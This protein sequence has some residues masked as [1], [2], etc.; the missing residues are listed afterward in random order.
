MYKNMKA[1]FRTFL[2]F[3]A[4]CAFLTGCSGVQSQS[5]E[6]NFEA[7]DKTDVIDHTK[8]DSGEPLTTLTITNDFPGF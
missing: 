6:D 3:A 1:F 2:T 8:G 4:I 7:I 5:D